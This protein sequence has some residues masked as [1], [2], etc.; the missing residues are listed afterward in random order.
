MLLER[1]DRERKAEQPAE[2]DA[3]SQTVLLQNSAC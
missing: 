3:R 2:P 1:R